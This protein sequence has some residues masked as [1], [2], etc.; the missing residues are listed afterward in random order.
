MEEIRIK[1]KE[2]KKSL[3]KEQNGFHSKNIYLISINNNNYFYNNIQKNIKF[4]SKLSEIEDQNIDIVDGEILKNIGYTKEQLSRYELSFMKI[5]DN[6][7]QLI[8]KNKSK[9]NI[10]NNKQLQFIEAPNP[11]IIFENNKSNYKNRDTLYR[12]EFCR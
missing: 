2:F 5:S 1:I 4:I 9:L 3:E 10:I 6:I 7:N 11:T 12:Y 8:F